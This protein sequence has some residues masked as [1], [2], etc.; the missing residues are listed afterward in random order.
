M[1]EKD[2]V[3]ECEK[4]FDRLINGRPRVDAH[5]GITAEKITSGVVSVEAGFDRGY[6]KSARL[7]H[8]PLIAKINAYRK[9]GGI[10]GDE[11]GITKVKRQLNSA[12]QKAKLLEEEIEIAH[13][14]RQA[15]I[16]QNIQL[17]ERVRLLELKII[18]LQP[19][20]KSINE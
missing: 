11:M 15:V 16:A 18:E 7:K 12:S 5:V 2:G 1:K 9:L 10:S 13:Y 4:A 20:L 8:Q 6:L 17:H 14:Q 19:S 3:Q